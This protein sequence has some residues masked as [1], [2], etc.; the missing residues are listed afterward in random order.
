MAA[1]PLRTVC[2]TAALVAC[3]APFHER[4]HSLR[5]VITSYAKIST[6]CLVF[7]LAVLSAY[8]VFSNAEVPKRPKTMSL[9][10]VRRRRQ[11]KER[12][13]EQE[14]AGQATRPPELAQPS[15]LCEGPVVPFS[16]LLVN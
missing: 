2:S 4:D 8:S 14:G 3:L 13:A 7:R 1:V 11:S 10:E 15:T 9:E 12:A 5:H 6:S 16:L